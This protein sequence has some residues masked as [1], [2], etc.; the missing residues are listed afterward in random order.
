MLWTRFI[1]FSCTSGFG[2]RKNKASGG[3]LTKIEESS[4][5]SGIDFLSANKRRFNLLI[6]LVKQVLV[7]SDT[8]ALVERV[9][10]T[11]RLIIRPHRLSKSGHILSNVVF[12]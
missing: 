3:E 1:C 11:V 8:S 6:P 9:F 5:V 2:C 7:V 12:L 10:T 4:T